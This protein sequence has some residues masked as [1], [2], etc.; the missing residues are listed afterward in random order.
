MDSKQ[1][2]F[3]NQG[4]HQN[5][6]KLQQALRPL[7]EAAFQTSKQAAPVIG[8]AAA[9]N[10]C[11]CGSLLAARFKDGLKL[12]EITATIAVEYM[13]ADT[14]FISLGSGKASADPFLG[15]LRQVYWP[16]KLP[17]IQ[18]GALA[19]F[20]TVQHAIDMK[21]HGVGFNVDVFVIEPKDKTFVARKL[22]D[23]E[24]EEHVEFIKASEEALRGVRDQIA[25]P[26]AA[27][28]TPPPPIM[29]AK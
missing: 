16:T 23:A 5:I 9:A 7:A 25:A 3:K 18:E 26:P 28:Q 10:D 22:E 21:V 6:V 17:T 2:E 20:W 1:Q 24:V 13:T 27:E 8:N 4:Y 12:V 15:L 14:P 19:A 29:P 11:I